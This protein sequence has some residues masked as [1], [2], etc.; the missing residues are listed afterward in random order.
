M[1]VTL[2]GMPRHKRGPGHWSG[3]RREPE[4]D[5]SMTIDEIIA[6]DV[7]VV[8]FR[9]NLNNVKESRMKTTFEQCEG[10]ECEKVKKVHKL[11][12]GFIHFTVTISSKCNELKS[13]LI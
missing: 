7:L 9:G 13:N 5:D 12:F 2:E 3:K 10:F 11:G 1:R 4:Q 8:V 6:S